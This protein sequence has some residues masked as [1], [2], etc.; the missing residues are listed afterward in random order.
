MARILLIDDDAAFRTMLR[1][2]LTDFGHV[3][4]EA[5]NGKEGM[6]LFPYADA[7]VVITDIV[8]PEKEGIEVLMELRNRRPPVKIIAISGA[9]RAGEVD[10]LYMA[11]LLGAAKVLA[12]PFTNEALCAAINA[13]V[14]EDLQRPDGA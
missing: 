7:E 14:A 5:R 13:L 1:A 6:E 4:I 12:K 9:G 8:M 2:T 3:V 10:Y 11:H